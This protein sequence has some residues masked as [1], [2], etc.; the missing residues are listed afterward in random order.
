MR[1][2]KMHPVKNNA[3]KNFDDELTDIERWG[4]IHLAEG[5]IAGDLEVAGWK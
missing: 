2:I 3:G 5:E 1:Q 4:D